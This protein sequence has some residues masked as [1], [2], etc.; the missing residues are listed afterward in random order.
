MSALYGS[1]AVHNV[2]DRSVGSGHRC[3]SGKA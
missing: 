2:E 3:A 1:E